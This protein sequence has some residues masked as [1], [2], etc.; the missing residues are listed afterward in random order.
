MLQ[1]HVLPDRPRGAP[2]H[3]H[4]PR[5]SPV[6]PL[7]EAESYRAMGTEGHMKGE[8]QLSAA[9]FACGYQLEGLGEVLSDLE[10]FE[11]GRD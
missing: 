3:S 8:S 11:R 1:Q 2:P 5:P 6:A 7:P 4:T 9:S 10:T